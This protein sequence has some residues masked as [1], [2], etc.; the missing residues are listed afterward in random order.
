M[1]IRALFGALITLTLCSGSFAQ[2]PCYAE[3]DGPTFSDTFSMGGP[4]LLVGIRFDAPTDLAVAS[5]KVFTGEGTGTNTLGIW[6]HDAPNNQPGSDLG[7]GSWSMS[8]TNSWQGATLPGTI[9][10]TAGS[11]YW[12]VWGPT[13]AAQS[14]IQEDTFP[15]QVYRGSFDGGASWN[16]PFQFNSIHWKFRMYCGGGLGVEICS[17]DGSGTAC[18]CGNSGGAGEGCANSTG[19][20]ASLSL[21]GSLSVG[22]D[23]LTVSLDQGPSGVPA[24]VFTG[25]LQANGGAGAVFGDGLLCATGNIQ[26][27]NV[28]FLDG[29]GSGTWGPG[30]QVLG[31]WGAGSTRIVQGWYRDNAGPCSTG[32]N[33]T[34]AFEVSFL[35]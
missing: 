17:G 4:N 3:N 35:P 1:K 5:I 12:L 9:N 8:S 16:G 25:T 28:E 7:T 21:G 34:Q 14:S 2:T 22:A 13:Q 31:G 33:T 26:R 11:T 27:L 23:D 24:I 10:L 19:V 20:G 6:S 15:G 32:F 29:S 30:L 18:P